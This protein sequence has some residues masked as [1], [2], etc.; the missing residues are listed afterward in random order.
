MLCF[1]SL[2]WS[3]RG[4]VGVEASH[5]HATMCSSK[6]FSARADR[7]D[8][9]GRGSII[10]YSRPRKQVDRLSLAARGAFDL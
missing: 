2:P 3:L 5:G 1:I 7:V 9:L 8:F 4:A 6:V 10:E